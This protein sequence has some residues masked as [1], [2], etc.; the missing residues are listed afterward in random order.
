MSK[1]TYPRIAIWLGF[2]LLSACSAFRMPT[3]HCAIGFDG[4]FVQ[5]GA[6]DLTR[7]EETWQAPLDLLRALGVRTIVVQ[8]TGDE[9]G[10]Y[11]GR[12]PGVAPVRALLRAAGV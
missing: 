3:L 9:H 2:W 11:D 12:A 8:F 4:S 5:L 10:S 7:D 1:S 6:R